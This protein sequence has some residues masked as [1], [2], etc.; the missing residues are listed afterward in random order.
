M[1]TDG[2]QLTKTVYLAP[3]VTHP[4]RNYKIIG[5]EAKL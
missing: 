2:V 3:H 4:K 1:W 5:K